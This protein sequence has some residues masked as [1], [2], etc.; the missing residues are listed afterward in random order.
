VLHQVLDVLVSNALEH[1]AGT[2]TVSVRAVAGALVVEVSDEGPG[3][4][5][6]A[7]A[8]AFR[9]GDPRAR[10]HG[11]GLALARDLTE[12]IGGRLT[13]SRPEPAPVVAVLLNQWSPPRAYSDRA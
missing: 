6:A 13:V 7:L 5:E 3:F 1:G 11:I 12:S 8:A 2:V 10:G 9:R 4:D